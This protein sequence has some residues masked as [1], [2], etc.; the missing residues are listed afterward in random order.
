MIYDHWESDEV[1]VPE[2]LSNKSDRLSA[3]AEKVEGRPSAKGNTEMKTRSRTQ[4]RIILQQDLT[5]VREAIYRQNP[6]QEPDE[7]VPQVR[8]W[9]GGIG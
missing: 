6:R 7:V 8:N 3:D 9:A 2:K 4:G 1:I 5:R